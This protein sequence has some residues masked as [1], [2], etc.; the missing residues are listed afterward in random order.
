MA[1]ARGYDVSDYQSSIPADAEFVIIKASEGARTVQ[2][3]YRS[4]VATARSRSLV[5]GHYHFLHAEQPVAGEVANFVAAVGDVPTSELL[6]LDFEPYSQGV[7][8][9]TATS[10]KNAWLAAVKAKFPRH[11]VGI[12]T[13]TDWWK[14]T[15]DN[16]GDFLWIAD[17]GAK[18]GSPGIQAAWK[19]HQFTD[20]PLDT[21]VYAGTIGEMRAWVGGSSAS[22]GPPAAGA[23]P[24]WPGLK[25]VSRAEWGARAY[26]TPGGATPY[27]ATRLGVKVHYLGTPYTA[28][29]HTGCAAY[30]RKLQASHMDGNGWSDIGYSFVVCEHG[31]VHEGRGLKRRNSANGTTSLNERHYAVCALLGS[32][33][34]TS[35]T[36]AQ[37]HG[38]RDAIEYCRASGPA[39]SEIRGH[40]DGYSTDC[41]G[42]PL[43]AWVQA[44]APR[45][46]TASPPIAPRKKELMFIPYEFAAGDHVFAT[47]PPG[48]GLFGDLG[49]VWLGVGPAT[50]EDTTVSVDVYT[51]DGQWAHLDDFTLENDAP[52]A[53]TRLPEG[54][55][56]VR[57]VTDKP[58]SVYL[59]AKE[60]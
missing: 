20:K 42:G 56:K 29:E 4:K 1:L 44:G 11:K 25:L 59:A 21:N 14:R 23:S 12:Y 6:V 41:P 39:G 48:G 30:V 19:I 53:E 46:A 15:D 36:D 33:G 60:S 8:N 32:S 52:K 18:A 27:S 47:E 9:A 43:Y 37:L 16:A 50:L 24:T 2:S 13:N 49:D 5:V 58:V 34:S 54:T 3:G 45:P 10:A 31:Y 57:I 28:G 40:R 22:N 38:V 51:Y 17:Y 26:V 35:P 55:C 7:S